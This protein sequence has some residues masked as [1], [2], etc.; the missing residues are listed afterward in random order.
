VP[1]WE[2]AVKQILEI[3]ALHRDM[4]FYFTGSTTLELQKERFPGRPIK[5]REFLP[6][7]FRQFC[8]L[9][10]S[11]RLCTALMCSKEIIGI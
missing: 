2:R 3:E 10:G 11:P 4:S 9:F 7:A 1:G 6:M 8:S 5:T